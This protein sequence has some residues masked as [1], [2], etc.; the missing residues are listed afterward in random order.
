MI[1]KVTEADARKLSGKFIIQI[2]KDDPDVTLDTTKNLDFFLEK[3]VSFVVGRMVT[4]LYYERRT[5]DTDEEFVSWFN[6]NDK[7]FHR[8]L[9]AK[10]LEVLFERFKRDNY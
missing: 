9:T 10:E 5:F 2:N 3:R 6:D 7:R 8:L 1:M 4:G